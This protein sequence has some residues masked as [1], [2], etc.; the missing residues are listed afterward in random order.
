MIFE[1]NCSGCTWVCVCVYSGICCKYELAD[2]RDLFTFEQSTLVHI[3]YTFFL[4]RKRRKMPAASKHVA[5]HFRSCDCVC[6]ILCE[7][8]CNSTV[9]V[10]LLTVSSLNVFL[11]F[12][13]SLFLLF[14]FFSC[15]LYIF[16][17]ISN[18]GMIIFCKSVVGCIKRQSSCA[19]ATAT[20]PTPKSD[21][22]WC[23]QFLYHR[24]PFYF[25][26]YL[27]VFI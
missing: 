26:I 13:L 2:T 6:M 21:W 1:S 18:A 11:Y 14:Q 12:S 8:D 25:F 19:A 20:K 9:N 5:S 15:F 16:N 7:C 17:H 4:P 23:I 10:C 3:V 22:D 24:F 27:C